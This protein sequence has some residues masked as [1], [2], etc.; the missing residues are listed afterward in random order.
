MSECDALTDVAAGRE[1]QAANEAGAEIGDDVAVQVGHAHHVKPV[2]PAHELHRGEMR[3]QLW[4]TD[5]QGGGGF[6]LDSSRPCIPL[7]RLDEGRQ[8][9]HLRVHLD[10]SNCWLVQAPGN[11][12]HATRGPSSL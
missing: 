6:S 9:R 12:G 7:E 3:A 5:T 1:A 2:G 4:D 11:A 10:D 8:R